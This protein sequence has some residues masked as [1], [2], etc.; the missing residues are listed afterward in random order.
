[1]TEPA[2]TQLLF[3]GAICYNCGGKTNNRIDF[4]LRCRT[5]NACL[6]S[7]LGDS[8][9]LNSLILSIPHD[10]HWCLPAAQVNPRGREG[11]LEHDHWRVQDAFD[12]E[13]EVARRS[14]S[15]STEEELSVILDTVFEERAKKLYKLREH[16]YACLAWHE[17]QE[18]ERANEREQRKEDRRDNIYNR[19]LAM[20]YEEDDICSISLHRE[21]WCDKPMSDRV[22]TRILPILEPLVQ[23]ALNDRLRDESIQ[24]EIDRWSIVGNHYRAIWSTRPPST[25]VFYPKDT[26]LYEFDII[27]PLLSRDEDYLPNEGFDS[28]IAEIFADGTFIAHIE[29]WAATRKITILSTLP[30]TLAPCPV[31]TFPP[32]LELAKNVFVGQLGEHTYQSLYGP[33]IFAFRGDMLPRFDEGAQKIVLAMIGMLGEDPATITTNGMSTIKALFVCLDCKDRGHV[34]ARNW[35]AHIDHVLT[36]NHRCPDDQDP[37][38]LAL[39]D[40]NPEC[41]DILSTLHSYP[42]YSSPRWWGCKHCTFHLTKPP[43]YFY[44]DPPCRTLFD[45]GDWMNEEEARQHVRIEHGISSPVVDHVYF[46]PC[47]R[48]DSSSVHRVNICW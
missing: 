47:H 29:N 35:R 36:K 5:C 24:R 28:L 15:I 43:A 8:V 26:E 32:E 10:Y 14:A 39:T 27:A 19:F 30:V 25:L 17:N 45:R 16:A 41:D 46:H 22:W 34:D 40:D 1:M 4:M 33:E 11:T 44:D 21:V 18:L 42:P 31:F 13:D 23:D 2:W 9:Y 6:K 3:G 20:G 48:Y 12:L 37:N 38:W 7:I